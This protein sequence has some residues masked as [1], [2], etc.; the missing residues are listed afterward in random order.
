[1]P[2]VHPGDQEVILDV[3][4]DAWTFSAR[5]KAAFTCG[6][7]SYDRSRFSS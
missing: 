3:M 2:A 7:L 4:P 6:F 5:S 1:M